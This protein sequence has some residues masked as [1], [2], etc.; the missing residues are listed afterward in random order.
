[1][2]DYKEKLLRKLKAKCA[3]VNQEFLEVNSIYEDSF[4]LFYQEV[5]LYCK[6]N[7]L[8]DPFSKFKDQKKTDSSPAMSDEF[9]SLYRKIAVK[10]HPD[11]TK[12]KDCIV[13]KYQEASK[14]KKDN[15]IYKLVSIAKDLKINLKE[16]SY[17]D[18]KAIEYSIIDTQKKIEEIRATYIWAWIFSPNKER[19][20]I[21]VRF[22]MNNV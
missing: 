14:A 18:I 10:T 5:L 6:E 7:D 3:E 8:K 19:Y 21:I 15:K 2:S 11:K 13:E 9:K 1:M 20:N 22:V 17:T 12:S 16:M 4:P